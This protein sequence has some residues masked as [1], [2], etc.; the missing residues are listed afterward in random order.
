[1]RTCEAEI[2]SNSTVGD[3]GVA[4]PADFLCRLV[5]HAAL[6]EFGVLV[7]LLLD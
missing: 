7:E 3:S 5:N 2:S 4:Q 6:P 1:M